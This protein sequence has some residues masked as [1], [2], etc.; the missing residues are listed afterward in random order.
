MTALP[1]GF[2]DRLRSG[3]TEGG[4][5]EKGHSCSEGAAGGGHSLRLRKGSRSAGRISRKI[6]FL[7]GHD[8]RALHLGAEFPFGP[9]T[10][11]SACPIDVR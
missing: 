7:L 11:R 8:L 4:C 9:V 3:K 2:D 6:R 5:R 1:T 10:L